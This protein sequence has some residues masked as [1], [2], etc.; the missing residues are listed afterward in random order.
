M[1]VE[2]P[3]W[4]R[5]LKGICCGT[6]GGIAVTLVG[7]PFDTLKVRL[8]TQCS[9]SPTYNGVIDCLKKT[10]KWEGV[11][12]LYKGV[13]KFLFIDDNVINISEFLSIFSYHKCNVI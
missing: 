1:T 10:I 9:T 13:G 7:H 8:Q 6:T 12:G 11:G 3:V 2:E 5:N 4:Y